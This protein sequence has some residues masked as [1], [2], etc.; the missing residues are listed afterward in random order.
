MVFA[1][2]FSHLIYVLKSKLVTAMIAL[3]SIAAISYARAASSCVPAKVKMRFL[4]I[5]VLK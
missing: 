2:G 1:A 3:Y 5:T 4:G